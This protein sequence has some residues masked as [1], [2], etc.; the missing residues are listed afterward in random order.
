MR[1]TI[2]G[3]AWNATTIVVNRVPP[4][5]SSTPAFAGLLTIL[6]TNAS[7]RSILLTVTPTG[8]G[9]Y[10]FA[11]RS[12]TNMA[13]ADLNAQGWNASDEH[14]GSTG[15]INFTTQTANRAAGT[16]SF[17]AVPAAATGATGTLNVTSG[18]FDV[19]F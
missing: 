1:A 10:T 7:S 14:A 11:P 2:N 4:N 17:L 18:T 19:T 16:F 12:A 3:T 8:P 15:S 9:N 13:V 6:G 5:N